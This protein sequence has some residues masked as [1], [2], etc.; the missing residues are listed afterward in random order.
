VLIVPR[1]SGEIQLSVDV[2]LGI[3][4]S[5]A[6]SF[7]LGPKRIGLPVLATIMDGTLGF[8]CPAAVGSALSSYNHLSSAVCGYRR[9]MFAAGTSA[10]P[11]T[12]GLNARSMGKSKSGKKSGKKAGAGKR[13]TG[14]GDAASAAAAKGVDTNRR[15]YVFQM[16]GVSKTLN[17]GKKILN[18]MNL[19]FFPGAK[20]G[21]L[22]RSS[23]WRLGGV[24][25]DSPCQSVS[26]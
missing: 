9:V 14:G 6:S 11:P 15:E 1:Q 4:C 16:Q 5:S 20:I 21:V 17:N 22:G 10:A 26:C 23:R 25:S 3:T 24:E 2:M 18:N 13:A 19:S 7:P 8:A 12:M